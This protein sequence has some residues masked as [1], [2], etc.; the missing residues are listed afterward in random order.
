MEQSYVSICIPG[1]GPAYL[2]DTCLLTVHLTCTAGEVLIWDNGIDHQDLTNGDPVE[3]TRLLDQ[4]YAR[5]EQGRL[6]AQGVWNLG[7]AEACNRMSQEAKGEL[8]VFLNCDTEPQP[9]WLEALVRAF[10]DP[11]VGVAGAM[12]VGPEGDL[13]HAG[14]KVTIGNGLAWADDIR[15]DLPTRDVAAVTGACLAIRRTIFE[16]LGGFD[17]GFWNL[18][19][20]IDLCLR[21]LQAGHRIRYIRESVVLHHMARSPERLNK[22][23]HQ[24]RYFQEKW[25]NATV[26]GSSI[27]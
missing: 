6:W 19:E 4:I 12:L 24:V 27:S 21:V 18:F 2:T 8:L 13:F 7:F 10:D 22:A 3:E 15:E 16:E 5:S 26:V 23:F 14:V 9:G 17:P 11:E 1:Y 20:D 25:A